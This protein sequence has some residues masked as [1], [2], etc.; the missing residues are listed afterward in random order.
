MT[1]TAENKNVT[2]RKKAGR[3]KKTIRR[4][5]LLMVRLTPTERAL[6]EGRAKNAGLRPSEWFRKAAKSARVFPRF[7]AEESGWFRMLAGLANNLNQLTHLAHVSGLFSLALKCQS[8]LRQI[9]ELLTKINSH[10]G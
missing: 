2:K 7:T 3:P 4:S 5:D 8:M 1:A 6:I 10:D 9:E